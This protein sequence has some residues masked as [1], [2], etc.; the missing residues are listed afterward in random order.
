M[1]E[2]AHKLPEEVCKQQGVAAQAQ[3]EAAQTYWI[4][5]QERSLQARSSL[6]RNYCR[7]YCRLDFQLRM[8]NKTYLLLLVLLA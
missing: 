7:T 3:Q 6:L 5:A 8:M 1:P 2:A 4:Q